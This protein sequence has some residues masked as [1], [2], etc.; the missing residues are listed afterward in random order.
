[1]RWRKTT[2]LYG[3]ALS[4][5]LAAAGAGAAQ[6]PEFYVGGEVELTFPKDG[7][8]RELTVYGEAEINGFY[9]GAYGLDSDDNASDEIGLYLGYRAETDG[10]FNYGLSYTRYFYPNDGGDCCGEIGLSLGQT[11]GDAASVSAEMTYDPEARL[12]GLDLGA[13]F[14]LSDQLSLSA[15]VGVNQQ[16]DAEDERTWDIGIGYALTDKAAVDLRYHDG[17]LTDGHL[18]LSL[19]FDTGFGK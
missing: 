11:L 18:G 3:A 12:A 7:N 13:A 15:N 16:E 6:E 19:T 1:M 14:D 10:G 4:A 2:L 5:A 8:V 17:N 9:A